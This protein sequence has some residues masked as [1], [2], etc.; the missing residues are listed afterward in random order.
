MSEKII[1]YDGNN[2]EFKKID[3][4]WRISLKELA[5]YYGI[6]FKNAS[7]NISRNKQLFRDINQSSIMELPNGMIGVL[8]I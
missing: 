2:I 5:G 1:S 4:I 7:K 3:E 8:H 6:Q